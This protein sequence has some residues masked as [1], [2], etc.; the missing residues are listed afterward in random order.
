MR[1]KHDY[2]KY[3]N[4]KTLPFLLAGLLVLIFLAKNNWHLSISLFGIL[5]LS[6]IIISTYLWKYSPFKYLFWV[7]NF[8]GRYEGILCYQ[9]KDSQGQTK[10]G[11]LKHI[12]LVNQNGHRITVSSFTIK[13][14]GKKSSLS[15]NKGMHV[16]KTEDEKHFK[17]IYNYLNDGSTEQGF[18]PHYGTE[19][20]KFIKK[21]DTKL[22]SG[23]YY[24]NREPFQTKGE[25][26][27]L[28]WV[29]NDLNHEY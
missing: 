4:S 3:Y 1:M 17:L 22:L 5:S 25:F 27:E 28:K 14:D 26:I 19:V 16:E 11:E 24:T 10:V 12:K 18:P 29:S 20:I 8:S 13:K 23:G 15:V 9:Y 6:L 7:D 21:N 2:F